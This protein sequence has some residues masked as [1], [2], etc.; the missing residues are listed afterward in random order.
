M[1]VDACSRC[2]YAGARENPL[3]GDGEIRS[4]ILVVVP[5][6]RQRDD[7]EN[8]VLAG[9]AG[10]RLEKMLK[11]ADISMDKVFR[12]PLVRCY[13]GREPNFHEFAA[14]KRCRGYTVSLIKLMRP[15]VV[16]VCGLKALKW[17][18]IRWTRESVDEATFPRWIGRAVRLKDIWGEIKFFV[19]E[20]PAVL[21][22]ARN[23][24][25]EEK[26]IDGLKTM[27]AYVSGQQKVSPVVPLEM[28]D[29]KK[30]V[31]T[32]TVQQTFWT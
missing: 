26:S 5:G 10:D 20:D 18:L 22:K 21:A 15:Q 11:G 8:K 32:K 7:K 25:A 16:V 14:F 31:Y 13:P 9:R 3:V 12:T 6:A 1:M 30:R 28:I 29:L 23:I 4:P 19:I 2:P 24:E 17:L 27:K